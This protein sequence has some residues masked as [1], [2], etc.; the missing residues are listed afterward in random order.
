MLAIELHA[1]QHWATL[2]ANS[3]YTGQSTCPGAQ[4]GAAQA[5]K[6]EHMLTAIPQLSGMDWAVT[7]I[8][9]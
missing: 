3:P 5:A 1:C 4:G 7:V 6:R 8:V 9:T 2:S